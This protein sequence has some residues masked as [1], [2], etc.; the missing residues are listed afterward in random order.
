MIL[1]RLKI[2]KING[3]HASLSENTIKES[4]DGVKWYMAIHSRKLKEIE[5]K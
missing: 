5:W 3:T 1:R 2:A 4:T